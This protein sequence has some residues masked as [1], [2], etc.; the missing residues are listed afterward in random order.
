MKPRAS[1][2]KARNR[3]LVKNRPRAPPPASNRPAQTTCHQVSM[4]KDDQLP[5]KKAKKGAA[6]PKKSREG[7]KKP[8]WTRDLGVPS[9]RGGFTPSTRVA[10]GRAG[11][12]WSFFDFEAGPIRNRAGPRRTTPSRTSSRSSG[13]A[14]PGPRSPS[15]SA[16]AA[17]PRPSSSTGAAAAARRPRSRS[18]RRRRPAPA[19]AR[20]PSPRAPSRSRRPRAASATSSRRSS[21]AT[22][23][24]VYQCRICTST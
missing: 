7:E 21:A 24:S 1:N 6:E 17:A 11:R 9:F 12:G 5:P 20:A 3:H 13:P 22:S 4:A 16:R 8:K 10:A 19:A 23:P 14:A 18:R 2:A 15:A